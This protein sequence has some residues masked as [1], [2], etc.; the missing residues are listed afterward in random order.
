MRV[1][2]TYPVVSSIVLTDHWPVTLGDVKVEWHVE[3]GRVTS[4][5]ASAPVSATDQM[6]TIQPS[7]DSRVTAHINL[8][9]S[10]R[11]NEVEE[12]IRTVWG[13]LSL[14]AH[15]EI[16]FDSVETTWVPE[17][18]EERNQ[19]HLPSFSRS[20]QRADLLQPRR[21]GYDL[22]ARATLSAKAASHY[23]IPL[24][25]LRRGTRA[26]YNGQYIEAFYNLFFFL[27]T[28]FAPGYSNPNK[29][30]QRLRTADAVRDAVAR[31]RKPFSR[32]SRLNPSKRDKLLGMTD[33]QIVDHLV[34]VRGQLHHHALSKP[35]VWHPDKAHDFHEEAIL[36]LHVV[37]AIAM[38]E[39]MKLLFAPDRNE[40]L[41]R[42][43]REAGATTK[44]RIEAV[45]LIDGVKRSLQPFMINVPSRRI[46]RAAVDGAHRLFREQFK[47]G[48][49]NVEV[50]EYKL[51]SE[52]ASQVYAVWQRATFD[53]P[54]DQSS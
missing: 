15:V 51:M 27:E 11:E 21:I 35:G 6:P 10:S 20:V 34:D 2:F 19:L 32:E 13:L 17:T 5:S 42:S 49:K 50:L 47:G 4:V 54:P 23:E 12:A 8:G 45:G 31:C 7:A 53:N 30:K 41:M 46:D 26:I 9:F 39:A 14:F 3:N 48:P 33:Q 40:D 29:V 16:D 25:F 24:G 52:D 22:V 18:S 44:L 38:S 37:H 1:K 43:A 28:L 36:L